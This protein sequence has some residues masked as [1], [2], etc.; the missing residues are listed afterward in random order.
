MGTHIV[1][2]FLPRKRRHGL[3][4][5]GDI[6]PQGMGRPQKLLG[7]ELHPAFGDVQAHI[8]LLQ[9]HPPLPLHFLQGER[10]IK[11]HIAQHIHCG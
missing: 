11:E 2:E 5:A 6:P 8:D 10:R 3:F 9:D 4:G 1:Q 7:H